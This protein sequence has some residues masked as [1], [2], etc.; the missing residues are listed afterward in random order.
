[1]VTVETDN[2]KLLRRYHVIIIML[3][4]QSGTVKQ[5]LVVSSCVQTSDKWKEGA[6]C[7]GGPDPVSLSPS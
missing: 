7:G 4:C 5:L 6:R 1:M 2:T 3:L